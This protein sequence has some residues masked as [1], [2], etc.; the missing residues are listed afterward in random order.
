MADVWPIDQSPFKKKD[1]IGLCARPIDSEKTQK[2]YEFNV[3]GA[4]FD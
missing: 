3:S 1:F 4:F 2:Q